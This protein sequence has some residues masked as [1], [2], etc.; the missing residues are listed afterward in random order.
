MTQLR[1]SSFVLSCVALTGAMMSLAGCGDTST[2]PQ[3]AIGPS[4]ISADYGPGAVHQVEISAN[5]KGQGFWMWTELS[6]DGTGDYEETD[7]IHLGG[8]HATDAA[9][10]DAGTLSWTISNGVLTMTNVQIIGGLETATFTVPANGGHPA[11]LTITVTSAIVPIVP[12]GTV[13]TM[14]AQ[15]QV[16]P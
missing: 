15:V 10:H 13:M 1:R 3:R 8:G 9:A 5:P 12:V 4:A 2:A 16:A 6:A 14:P 7:C 11:Q